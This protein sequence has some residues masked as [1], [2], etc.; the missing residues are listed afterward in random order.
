MCYWSR[1]PQDVIGPENNTTQNKTRS[2]IEISW[3]THTA[4]LRSIWNRN[5]EIIVC[6]IPIWAVWPQKQDQSFFSSFKHIHFGKPTQNTHLFE[7]SCWVEIRYGLKIGDTAWKCLF[8]GEK[9]T[10]RKNEK[11]FN[12]HAKRRSTFYV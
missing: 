5:D 6:P 12:Y 2:Q 4:H 3:K 8:S 10:P 7:W 9:N 11:E 1:A